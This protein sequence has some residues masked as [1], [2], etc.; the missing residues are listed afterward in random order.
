VRIGL[1]IG[2]V[3]LLLAPHAMAQTNPMPDQLIDELVQIDC[4]MPGVSDMGTFGGFL[5][6][7][8][9]MEPSATVLIEQHGQL[10]YPAPCQNASVQKIMHFGPT[11]LPALIRH[12]DDKRPT[13]LVVGKDDARETFGGQYFAD[14]YDARHRTWPLVQCRADPFCEKTRS[15]DGRY[16]VKVADI[17]FMLIGQIVSRDLIAVRYQPTA[18]VMVNSP[19]ETPALA[20]RVKADWAG[21]GKEGLKNSLLADLRSAKLEHAPD[22]ETEAYVLVRIHSDAL[23]RLRYYFPDTYASLTGADLEKRNASESADRTR[24]QER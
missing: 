19:I 12:L 16:T 18:I 5:P 20:D 2:V 7:E 21:I 1:A 6:E 14:E 10:R 15:F 24:L 13:K 3:G 9:S 8:G 4:P 11:A 23:H 17:C 22:A